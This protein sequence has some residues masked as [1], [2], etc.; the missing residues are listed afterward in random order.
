[1]NIGDTVGIRIGKNRL[2]LGKVIGF[3]VGGGKDE[4]I[5]KTDGDGLEWRRHTKRVLNLRAA[6]AEIARMKASKW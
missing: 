5:V 2:R 3:C 1:M 6:K 4:L